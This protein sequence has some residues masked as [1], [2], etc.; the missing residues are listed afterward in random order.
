MQKQILTEKDYK[1]IERL[2]LMKQNQ[3]RHFLA[4]FV[5]DYYTDYIINPQYIVAKGDIPVGLVAH[6]DTVWEADLK[7]EVFY[8]MRKN[9]MLNLDGGG[10]DDKVGIFLIMKLVEAG[11]RPH[12]IFTT[13]EECGCIGALALA[14]TYEQYPFGELSY[15]I[16]LDRRNGNDCVFYDCD[17]EDFEQ[18]IQSFGFKTAYGSFTDICE[19]C[20]VWGMA[21]VNLSV[22]YV[23]EH[24]ASEKLYIDQMYNTLKRVSTILS[25][26]E[27]PAFEYIPMVYS[28][29]YGYGYGGPYESYYA[30]QYGDEYYYDYEKDDPVQE[31]WGYSDDP[32]HIYTCDYCK[33]GKPEREIFPVLMLDGTMKYCCCD[34]A[35]SDK[36]LLLNWCDRCYRTFQLDP[37]YP[38]STLCHEC[39]NALKVKTFIKKEKMPEVEETH[40]RNKRHK[41]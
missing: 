15:L 17:N 27:F 4:E 9:V 28:G 24:T 30:W 36:G 14:N 23:N 32:D 33:K 34:C 3:V 38:N 6:M 8:D 1:L 41:K 16:Q 11:F 25:E 13:D 31:Y 7:H 37:K 12:I 39:E 21:G 5:A 26:P 2:M 10:Y 35:N 29:Y 18:Y 20:P 40:G 19:L 22:G